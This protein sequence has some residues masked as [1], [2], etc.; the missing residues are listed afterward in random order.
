MKPKTTELNPTLIYFNEFK[1][2]ERTEASY[3]VFGTTHHAYLLQ[4]QPT[5]TIS[6]QGVEKQP[7]IPV[8]M[9]Q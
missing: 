6:T 4:Q 2:T 8:I 5:S 1:A 3:F 9:I 7:T